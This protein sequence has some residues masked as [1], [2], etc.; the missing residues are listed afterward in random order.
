MRAIVGFI[1]LF[2]TRNQ[3][4]FPVPNWPVDVW[5]YSVYHFSNDVEEWTIEIG[6]KNGEWREHVMDM[7]CLEQV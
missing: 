4:F 6:F 1:L 5:L 2:V 3:D 7:Q